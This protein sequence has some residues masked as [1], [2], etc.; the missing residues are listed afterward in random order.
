VGDGESPI[1]EPRAGAAAAG[2]RGSPR[3]HGRGSG[4]IPSI[5][6]QLREKGLRY[7]LTAAIVLALSTTG[8]SFVYEKLHL[9]DA[10]SYAFQWLLEFGWRPAE[11]KFVRLLLIDDQEY[12]LG[13]LEGRR[14]IKRDYLAHLIDQLVAADVHVIALDFDVRLP[15]PRSTEVPSAYRA[16]T[17][18][19]IQA[20]KNAALRGK[21]IVLA[22]PISFTTPT[23]PNE[24][25][26]YQQ[27]P[28]IYQANGL[29]RDDGEKWTKNVHCGYIAL[30]TDPLA[31]PGRLLMA[32]GDHLDS[33]ALAIARAW[34]PDL[35][36]NLLA[37]VGDNARHSNFISDDTFTKFRAKL[38]TRDLLAGSGVNALVSKAVIVGGNWRRDA[39][40]RGPPVDTHWT[41]VGSIVGAELHANFAE[42]LVDG[43]V[44]R[45]TSHRLLEAFEIGLSILAAIALAIIPGIWKKVAGIVAMLIVLFVGQWAALHGFGVFFDV[46]VPLV[47]LGLH[48]LYERLLGSAAHSRNHAKA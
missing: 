24:K 35:T 13:Q 18:T 7:W 37:R 5:L 28:D 30:P 9:V 15:D 44:F 16:E 12:W 31:I 21:K 48:A 36:A 1:R 40:G 46:F 42:A 47:G 10:R 29:C 17:E 27:D 33:F 38:T 45:A 8:S 14:P 23:S 3:A 20:I 25:R 26:G 19:L 4:W 34:D 43:R 2:R 6:H 39:F 11:P 32:S 22:T 41:P